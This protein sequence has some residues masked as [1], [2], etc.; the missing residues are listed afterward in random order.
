M[1]AKQIIFKFNQESGEI[2]ESMR[3]VVTKTPTLTEYYIALDIRGVRQALEATQKHQRK[4]M[5]QMNQKDQEVS[6]LLRTQHQLQI[7]MV[8][9]N[10]EVD[11]L[12]KELYRQQDRITALETIVRDLVLPTN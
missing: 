6:D 10:K 11:D 7:D 1:Y 4:L 2:E 12:Q 9:K 3:Q 8:N 5:G